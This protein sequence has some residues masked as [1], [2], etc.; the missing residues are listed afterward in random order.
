M[1]TCAHMRAHMHTFVCGRSIHRHSPT[2]PQALWTSPPGYKEDAERDQ[3]SQQWSHPGPAAEQVS[4]PKG[5]LIHDIEGHR[6]ERGGQVY[7]VVFTPE[8]AQGLPHSGCPVGE[9]TSRPGQ[10]IPNV[11]ASDT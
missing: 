4:L 11:I 3:Q 1:H 10:A 9:D 5:I 2:S 8:G 6:V 7:L